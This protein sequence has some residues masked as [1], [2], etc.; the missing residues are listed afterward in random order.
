MII[1]EYLRK[2]GKQL[3]PLLLLLPLVI[4]AKAQSNCDAEFTFGTSHCP[5]I[6]FFDNSTADS[7]IVCWMFDYQG[8]G[9]VDFCENA[10]NKF[11]QNGAFEVCLSIL[12]IDGCMDTYC[13]SIYID[14]NC[15]EPE[16]GYMFTASN[17]TCYFTDTTQFFNSTQQWLW[18]FGDGDT[19][20]L[21]HPIH[22]YTNPGTY[23]ACLTVTDSCDS[24]MVCKY[25]TISGTLGATVNDIPDVPEV[26]A[27]P[28]PATDQLQLQLNGEFEGKLE[29]RL[30]DVQGKQIRHLKLPEVTT[31]SQMVQLKLSD[32]N[33]AGIYYIQA[34]VGGKTVM[35]DRIMIQR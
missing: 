14:C 11:S 35:N 2:K 4:N 12:T 8:Q 31:G 19:S 1:Q 17:D 26:V 5:N 20:T 28:N 15:T 23:M 30:F 33:N 22:H 21:Q 3:L 16:V 24:R 9:S 32:I 18:D 25:I 29:I 27:F 10:H 7:A 34:T 6:Y 13:D